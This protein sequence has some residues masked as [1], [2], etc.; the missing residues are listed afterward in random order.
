MGRASWN[1]R[2]GKVQE[3]E[4]SLHEAASATL[5]PVV[6]RLLN[7]PMATMDWYNVDELLRKHGEH[8]NADMLGQ[9]IAEA[10]EAMNDLIEALEM[11]R[12]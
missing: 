1:I 2:P 10:R 9:T 7:D 6:D 3:P 12:G 8:E 4:L 11:Q 5:G